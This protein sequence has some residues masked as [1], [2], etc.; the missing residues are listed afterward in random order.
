MVEPGT[1][2]VIERQW[3][4]GDTVDIIFP[5]ELQIERHDHDAIVVLRGPTV[6]SMPLGEEWIQVGGEEPH[7][8]WEV[9]RTTPW[10]YGLRIDPAD[11]SA[12]F[13]VEETPVAELPFS[14]EG[15]PVT[16]R[17]IGRQVPE[18][19]M[20]DSAAG[21]LPESPVIS[22]EPD[23]E[24]TLIPYGSTNLRVTAFPEVAE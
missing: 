1:Y 18:W 15:A 9:H 17:A 19:Q 22:T 6:F 2:H 5:M 20:L 10:N 4:P 23:E 24:V 8:D 12:S 7:A 13:E 14:P 11:P 21:P 3:H 16:I